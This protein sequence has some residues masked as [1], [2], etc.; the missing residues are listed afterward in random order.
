[1]QQQLDPTLQAQQPMTRNAESSSAASIRNDSAKYLWNQHYSSPATVN[2][3]TSAATKSPIELD[4]TL[5]LGNQ[6]HPVQEKLYEESLIPKHLLSE[7]TL[8]V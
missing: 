5:T 4:T 8:L 7:D 1:M 3:L 6:A 2:Q